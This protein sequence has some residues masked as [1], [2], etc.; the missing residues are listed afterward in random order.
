M[1]CEEVDCFET[2]RGAHSDGFHHL[3][4]FCDCVDDLLVL[5][6]D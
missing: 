2:A 6:L 4:P 3:E 5:V 1:R